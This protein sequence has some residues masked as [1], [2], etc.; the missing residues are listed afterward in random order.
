[1]RTTGSTVK[2]MSAAALVL[3]ACARMSAQPPDFSGTWALDAARSQIAADAG[4]AGLIASG[5]PP[6]L[7]VTQP[8]NG[9]L[10]IESE[11][12]E[13]HVRIYNPRARST[14]PVFQGGTITMMSKW[15]GRRL[16]SEGTQESPSGASTISKQ[17]REAIA[18]SADGRTLSVEIVTAGGA[19][20]STST[21]VYTR[22]QDVGPCQTWTTPCKGRP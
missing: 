11:I 2:A 19:A 9:T 17:V 7:H 6:R 3:A 22:T 8:A 16:L 14:S 18:L 5:A 20:A 15:D 1:M 12:N 10:V 21:L 4:F 13:G